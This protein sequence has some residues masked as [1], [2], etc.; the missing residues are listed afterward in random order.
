MGFVFFLGNFAHPLDISAD[1]ENCETTRKLLQVV[2][3]DEQRNVFSNLVFDNLAFL[4][5]VVV[6]IYPN[7]HKYPK[8]E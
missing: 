6:A 2:Y 4:L 3:V 1:V 7:G 8:N 5:N